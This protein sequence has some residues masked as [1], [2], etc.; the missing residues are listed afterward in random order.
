M[1]L[2]EKRFV[3]FV[4]FLYRQYPHCFE[5][6][7]NTWTE[8]CD[9]E[10]G[11][12]AVYVRTLVW[13]ETASKKVFQQEF[14][15][16]EK[17]KNRFIDSDPENFDAW[18]NDTIRD[19]EFGADC[20]GSHRDN[21]HKKHT[22][23][24]LRD[25]LNLVNGSQIRFFKSAVSFNTLYGKIKAIHSFGSLTTVDFLERLYRSKHMFIKVYPKRF[26]LTGGGVQRGLLKIYFGSRKIE[27]ETKGDILL[28]RI[29]EKAS[30]P[31]QIAF[32]E[33]ESILCI[34]QKS[35][36]RAYFEKLLDGEIDPHDFAQIYADRYFH[37]DLRTSRTSSQDDCLSKKS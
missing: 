17:V 28:K 10:D 7:H 1:N 11:I 37:K 26:Y 22:A 15:G 5:Y 14:G 25:Y 3:E 23:R 8:E 24:A 31:R 4:D 13:N 16:F 36:T 32:F 9:G 20:R 33:I 6:N 19:I 2:R 30:I 12:F 35:K 29:L 18:V 34:S 21:R 27:L